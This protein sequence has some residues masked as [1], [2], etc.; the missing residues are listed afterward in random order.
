MARRSSRR[1]DALDMLVARD[2]KAVVGFRCNGSV[3][4]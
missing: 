2:V 4:L 3:V 1:V